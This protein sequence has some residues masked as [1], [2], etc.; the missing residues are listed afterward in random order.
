MEQV[1]SQDDQMMFS[2]GMPNRSGHQSPAH[3]GQDMPITFNMVGGRAND[4]L[5]SQQK[6]IREA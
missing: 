5:A 2:A 6:S 3:R 1:D 4:C